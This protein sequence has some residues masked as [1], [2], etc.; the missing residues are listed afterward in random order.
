MDEERVEALG[1]EPIRAD[2]ERAGRDSAAHE[3]LAAFVGRLERQGGAGFFGAYVDTDDRDSDRYLVNIVQGGLGL[4]DESYYREDKFADDPRGL[5][6]PPGA[7]VRPR[8]ASTDAGPRGAAG[9]DVETRLAAGHWERAATRDVLKTYNLMAL[10][11]LQAGRAGLRL[12]RLGRPRSAPTSDAGRGRRPAAQ[13]R[14]APL[15]GARRDRPRRT[16]RPGPRSG[17]SRAAAPYLSSDF[18]EESFYF[19]GRTLNGTPE[20]RARWKRGVAFVEGAVGEAVGEEYVA[21][22]FPPRA[23][24]MMDELVANLIEAYRRSIAAWTG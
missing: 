7:D 23:K 12:G 16:G 13:L 11:D 3:E 2:L 21:R 14:R 9:L 22:H 6:G 15:G 8:L 10:A 1:A 5:P 4:P 17:S 19:Y 18:V 20:L 24:E